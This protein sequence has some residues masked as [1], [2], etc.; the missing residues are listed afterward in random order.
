MF[1]AQPGQA[2]ELVVR[3]G[4]VFEV[5]PGDLRGVTSLLVVLESAD[6]L[7]QHERGGFNDAGELVVGLGFA[8]GAGVYVVTVPEPHPTLLALTALL[9][10]GSLGREA[11][12]RPRASRHRGRVAP[13]RTLEE[14]DG[15]EVDPRP[16]R[17]LDTEVGL[18]RRHPG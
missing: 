3:E 13:G 14:G 7:R 5:S 17:E 4:G 9:A 10:A 2:P 12:G 8:G 18:A 6:F 15:G 1:L 16:D 11:R